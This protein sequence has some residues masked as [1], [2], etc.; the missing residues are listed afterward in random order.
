MLFPN[1]LINSY[2][3]LTCFRRVRLFCP[4]P[5]PP[6]SVFDPFLFSFPL[7]SESVL[8]VADDFLGF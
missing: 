5:F 7:L 2:F 8:D 6:W 1:Q 3:C 4:F